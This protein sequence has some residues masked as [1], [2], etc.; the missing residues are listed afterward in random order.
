MHRSASRVGALL[1]A[2]GL[3]AAGCAQGLPESGLQRDYAEYVAKLGSDEITEIS[4]SRNSLSVSGWVDGDI[5]TYDSL[6]L[7]DSLSPISGGWKTAAAFDLDS[8]EARLESATCEYP[9]LTVGVAPS[10]AIVETLD[11]GTDAPQV[12]LDGEAMD[13]MSNTDW[14]S[15]FVEI[16]DEMRLMLGDRVSEATIGRSATTATAVLDSPHGLFEV[17]FTMS[18]DGAAPRLMQWDNPGSA[19]DTFQWRGVSGAYVW[20]VVRDALAAEGKQLTEDT[21]VRIYGVDGVPV[22]EVYGSDPI[23]LR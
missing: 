1:A 21:Q 13:G 5:K 18:D 16:V 4:I 23:A 20:M 3:T 12:W 14:E 6:G 15:D 7:T 9:R 8:Y 2:V 19:S 17:S 11:C 10:A 22:A